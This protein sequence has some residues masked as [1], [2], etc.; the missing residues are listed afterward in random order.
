[1][2]KLVTVEVDCCDFCNDD[3]HH[4]TKC[5]GCGKTVCYKCEKKKVGVTYFHLI[6]CSG[7]KDGFY[8]NN[9]DSNPVV[10]ATPLHQAF[11]LIKNLRLE[12]KTYQEDFTK[13]QK[14][15]EAILENLPRRGD[16]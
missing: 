16:E 11:V 6:Y 3:E 13:R 8:C 5:E 7:P 9:C 10:R 1:M 15:V 4:Y 14:N 12:M 2:L